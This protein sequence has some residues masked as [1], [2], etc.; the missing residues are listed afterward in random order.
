M[1]RPGGEMKRFSLAGVFLLLLIYG[2]T[3]QHA[4]VEA[5]EISAQNT[6]LLPAGKEADGIIGDFVLRNDK[7]HALISGNLPLRRANMST[8]YR[9]ITPGCLYDLDLRDAGNDQITVFRPGDLGGELSWV[10]VASDGSSGAGVIEA[11]RTAAKGEGLYTRHEY[12]LEPG[13]QHVL[14]T[15]TYKNESR[16]PK[17][18]TPPPVWKQFSQEWKV[19]DVRV[20]DSIDPADK[21]AYAWGPVAS[22]GAF[23]FEASATLAPG[24]QRTYA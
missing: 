7:V 15:S 9:F 12:R 21:R 17:K 18:I 8:E 4:Q 14:V 2:I 23:A 11:V 13:W 24:E 3:A 22:K 10:R 19:G 6:R 5:V 16:E 1:S 20:G